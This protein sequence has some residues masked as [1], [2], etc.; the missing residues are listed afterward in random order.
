ML[1]LRL[2]AGLK[3]SS[4]SF[5]SPSRVGGFRGLGLIGSRVS[6]VLGV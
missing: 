1:R 4:G 6:E 2:L 5:L 3:E